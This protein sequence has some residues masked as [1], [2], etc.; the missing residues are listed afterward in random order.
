MKSLV[1]RNVIM[2]LQGISCAFVQ[3]YLPLPVVHTI[4]CSGAIFVCIV[5]YLRY[6]VS[7]SWEQKK[8][9]AVGFLGILLV[10]N[11]KLLSG[12]DDSSS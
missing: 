10:I 11:N 2:T 12:A 7:L 3:F 1:I 6:E 8:G 5:D 9:V 4:G